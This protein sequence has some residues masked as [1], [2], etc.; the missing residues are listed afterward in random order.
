MAPV[1]FRRVNTEQFLYKQF[2]MKILTLFLALFLTL[3]PESVPFVDVSYGQDV[4]LE[5][6]CDF[7]E[8]AIFCSPQRISKRN[9]TP[10]ASLFTDSSPVSILVFHYHPIHFCF[11]RSWLIACTL[12]L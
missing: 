5:E 11:E 3:V 2:K 10:S 12:R 4:C 1:G 7:E 9:Q 6:S 8:E